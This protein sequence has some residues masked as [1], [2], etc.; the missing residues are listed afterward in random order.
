MEKLTKLTNL[1]DEKN[2]DCL[3]IES[4]VTKNYLNTLEGSGCKV[5]VTKKESFLILDGRYLEQANEHE[6]ELTIILW[7]PQD[8]GTTYLTWIEKYMNQNGLKSIGVEATISIKEYQRVTQFSKPYLLGEEL[9]RVRM[10][11]TIEEINKLSKAIQ[12]A[13]EIYLKVLNQL[14]IGMTDYEIAGLLSYYCMKAG[15]SGM[16]F[17]TIIGLG[18]TSA[19]PHVRPSGKTIQK[20]EIIMIDFGLT[21]D[22]FQSDMT[23]MSC[24]G[25]PSQLIRDIHRVVLRANEAG[26]SQIKQGVKARDVD[27]AARDV[28]EEAGYGKYFNH[29]LGH[30]IGRDNSTELPK[31]NAQSD[32]TLENNM[33]MSCEPGIY[34][35]KVGGVRIEDD[36]WIHEGKGIAL[37]KIDKRI[38][39]L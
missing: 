14:A 13:D 9:N 16:A 3:L 11:K 23:R 22:G 31:L 20:G 6:K 5:F 24:F 18:E 30:G 28:I 25:K 2:I 26:I 38:Q 32:M 17:D 4:K 37:N 34:I 36:I 19:Y 1:L 29:G 35:P 21:L 33:V 12:I 39:E 8:E 27:R 15:A 7:N 10:I